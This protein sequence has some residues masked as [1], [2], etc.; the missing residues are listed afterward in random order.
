MIHYFMTESRYKEYI[1]YNK[2]KLYLIL[3]EDI[4]KALEEEAKK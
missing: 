1:I 2:K 3:N 4:N